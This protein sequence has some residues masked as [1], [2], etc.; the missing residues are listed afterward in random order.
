MTGW[1]GGL[2]GPVEQVSTQERQLGF[3]G[4][5]VAAQEGLVVPAGHPDEFAAGRSLRGADGGL[6]KC[7]LILVADE[8]QQRA[9]HAGCVSGPAGRSRS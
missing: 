3:G 7:G 4:L 2:V 1:C 5:F 6:G 8:H 9:Q